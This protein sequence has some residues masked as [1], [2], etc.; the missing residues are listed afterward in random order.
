MMATQSDAD[1]NISYY[2]VGIDGL[3]DGLK[4]VRKPLLLHIAKL[5]TYVSPEAQAKIT[6]GTQ[7]NELIRTFSYAN[8]DHAFARVNGIHYQA[9]AA[10][11]ANGRSAEA[12]AAALG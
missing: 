2:G 5:D 4:N 1:V 7:G 8:A 11:I 3:L 6:A 9:L 12:L 10:T